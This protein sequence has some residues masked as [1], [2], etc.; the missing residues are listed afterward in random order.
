MVL[1]RYD[2][3]NNIWWKSKVQKEA[4]VIKFEIIQ[5]NALLFANVYICDARFRE[6]A[7]AREGRRKARVGYTGAPS[8]SVIFYSLCSVIYKCLF[9]IYIFS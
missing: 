2:L 5:R 6:V 8:T 3:R 7:P 1:G 9:S 4:I